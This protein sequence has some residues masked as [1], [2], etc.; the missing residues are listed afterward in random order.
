MSNH[1]ENF[2]QLQEELNRQLQETEQRLNNLQQEVINRNQQISDQN[3][4]IRQYE[5]N[6]IAQVSHIVGKGF[7]EIEKQYILNRIYRDFTEIKPNKTKEQ[8]E[9]RYTKF[10]KNMIMHFMPDDEQ[11]QEQLEKLLNYD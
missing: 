6:T 4:N 5:Q 8:K 2:R 11:H 10:M 1:E 9:K 3:S 7:N